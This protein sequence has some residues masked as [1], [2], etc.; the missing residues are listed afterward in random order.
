MPKSGENLLARR[1]NL[2]LL[3]RIQRDLERNRFGKLGLKLLS[4]WARGQHPSRKG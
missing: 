4:N 1:E 3:V 2:M